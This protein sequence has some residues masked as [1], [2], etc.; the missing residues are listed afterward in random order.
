MRT[1]ATYGFASVAINPWSLLQN[2]RPTIGAL[3]KCICFRF[4]LRLEFSFCRYSSLL[5]RLSNY[6]LTNAIDI[7]ICSFCLVPALSAEGRE[8]V[9]PP[10]V[11]AHGL[12]ALLAQYV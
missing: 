5:V 7:L 11:V 1:C 8:H 10:V 9:Y 6:I 12:S 2:D 3:V 4:A